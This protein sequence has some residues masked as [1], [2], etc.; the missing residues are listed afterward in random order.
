[1]SNDEVWQIIM[2]NVDMNTAI[3]EAWSAALPLP[4]A[5]GGKPG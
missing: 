1:M 2:G 5:S 4:K 3:I